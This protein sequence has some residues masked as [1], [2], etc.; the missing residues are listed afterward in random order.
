M[1]D[2]PPGDKVV[3]E[4]LVDAGRGGIEFLHALLQSVGAGEGVPEVLPDGLEIFRMTRLPVLRPRVETHA[5]APGKEEVAAEVPRRLRQHKCEHHAGSVVR[6]V[7]GGGVRGVPPQSPAGPERPRAARLRNTYTH[8]VWYGDR[9]SGVTL[10]STHVSGSSSNTWKKLAS[11]AVGTSSPFA[12]F[13]T[14]S[15]TDDLDGSRTGL[16]RRALRIRVEEGPHD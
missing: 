4:G 5:V 14:R 13:S 16:L 2:V 1:L 3:L 15:F 9:I 12:A 10:V 8:L 6:H 11:G 7:L